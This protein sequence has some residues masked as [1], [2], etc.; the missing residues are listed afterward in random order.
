MQ[1]LWLV[2]GSPNY[3]CSNLKGRMTESR[4]SNWPNDPKADLFKD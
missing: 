1:T 2:T 4:N 3:N